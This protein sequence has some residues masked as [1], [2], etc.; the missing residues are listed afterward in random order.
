MSVTHK[1]ILKGDVS[2]ADAYTNRLFLET[3]PDGRAPVVNETHAEID[4]S[5]VVSSGVII[6][7]RPDTSSQDILQYIEKILAFCSRAHI[8]IASLSDVP[9]AVDVL[10]MHENIPNFAGYH[11]LS[12]QDTCGQLLLPMKHCLRGFT[13]QRCTLVR[14]TEIF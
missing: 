10:W 5:Y 12:D 6:F 7:I 9:N 1:I 13:K 11:V 4:A 3:G 14:K 2:S 8:A